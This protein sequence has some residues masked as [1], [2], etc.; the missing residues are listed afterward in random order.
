MGGVHTY[1]RRYK[2]ERNIGG[3]GG[4]VL[5]AHISH[6]DELIGS[7]FSDEGEARRDRRVRHQSGLA[8]ERLSL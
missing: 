2:E 8:A 1:I 7:Y 3:E 4:G 5:A 6:A